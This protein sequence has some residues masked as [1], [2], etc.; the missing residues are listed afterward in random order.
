MIDLFTDTTRADSLA[1][2]YLG[3]WSRRENNRAIELGLLHDNLAARGY[4]AA[5]IAAALQKLETATDATPGAHA[6]Q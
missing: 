2:R 6:S 4:S 1:Y 3:E 5:H